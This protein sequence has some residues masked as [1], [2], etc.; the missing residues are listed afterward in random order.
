MGD[1]EVWYLVE[2]SDGFNTIGCKWVFKTKHNSK[3][4]TE[5]YKARLVIPKNQCLGIVSIICGNN[6]KESGK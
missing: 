6:L 1:N 2:L 5:R 3:G 4:N